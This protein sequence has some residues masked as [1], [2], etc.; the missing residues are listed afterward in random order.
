MDSKILT[1]KQTPRIDIYTPGDTRKAELLFE[2]LEEYGTPLY[3]WQKHV[4]RRWLAEDEDGNFVNT[5]CG[6][7]LA[8][9]NGKLLGEFVKLPTPDGWR[10][11][12]DIKVGDYVFG[13]DG[14]PTK[15]LAKYEPNE[16]N[17]YEIDFG[18][19]GNFVN[20]T[21]KAGGGH[22]WSVQTGDWNGK[23]KVVDSNWIYQNF[24]RLKSH[25]QTIRIR[26]TKPVEYPKKELPLDPYCLGFWL[27]DG[28]SWT[29]AITCN[30]NDVPVAAHAFAKIGGIRYNPDISPDKKSI[31]L[32]VMGLKNK[33][34]E[35]GVLGN[36]HIPPEYLTASVEQRYELLRGLMDSDG[37]AEGHSSMVSWSQSGRPELVEQ[38]MELVCSLGM[39]PSYRKRELSK[40][41]PNCKDAFEIKFNVVGKEPVFKSKRRLKKFEKYY[42]KE[43]KFNYWYI[44][45]IRKI[46]KKE[47]Y[48]CLSVDNESHLFLCGKSYIPTHNSVL[49]VARII[50]GI[51]FRKAIGLYTAQQLSTANIVKRRVQDFFYESEYEEI[52]NLLT[53]RFREKPR[54]YDFIEF[55]NGARYRFTT[56]SRMNGLG[57]TNDEVLNDEAADMLDSHAETLRPTVS[58]AKTG[59]PQFIFA[60]TP[61]MA[62]TVGEVFARTRKKILSGDPGCWQEW[63]VETLTDPHDKEA[64]FRTNPSLGK[65]LLVKAVEDEATSLSLDG[66]NRM[67]L[68]W[69]AGVENKRA[70]QQTDWDACYTAK[71]EYDESYS[72]IFAVK[73]SPDRSMFA[74]AG[75]R[76]LT[77]GRVH[78]EI[79]MYRPMTDGF[80]KIVKYFSDSPFGAKTPRW[81]EA[82]RIIVDG[83]TGQAILFEDMTSSGIPAK[84]ILQ[85]NVREISSAHE[86]IFNAIK[87]H[88]FSHYRQP[89]LDQTVRITKT[90]PIGRQG[91]FGWESMNREMTTCALDA[92]TLAYWG[93]KTLSEREPTEE[94]KKKRSEKIRNIL[95]AV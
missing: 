57:E 42:K 81:R 11:M 3:E 16:K 33:L 80:Q 89:V 75:A 86:F 67:R 85:P 22:L 43:Q 45:D 50:Y 58:A 60:G 87:E 72:K 53:P 77:N 71:P 48:Y 36:K 55:E 6:L 70:I 20:E 7:S 21:I 63:S 30:L 4:L 25:K 2:L 23:E 38:F 18:N 5:T 73:F 64:W 29:G 19:A 61:P 66:F 24:P 88:T 56:R 13:D 32:R 92:A 28:H 84:K 46:E 41:N 51:I 83:A 95:S 34:K 47:H 94:E 62:E 9:Q 10:E 39:K 90:R 1:P 8:R 79:V 74:I 27:G 40:A 52:F 76:Q 91:A 65:S 31:D 35:I 68:G 59:N 26:L 44:K 49:F 93:A 37:Y 78:V 15:V 69:W 14:K 82:S 54:N 12:R 17:F